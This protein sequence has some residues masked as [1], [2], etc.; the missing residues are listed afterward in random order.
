MTRILILDPGSITGWAIYNRVT[1]ELLDSSCI[2]LSKAPANKLT[3]LEAELRKILAD[4]QPDKIYKE[5]KY[6]FVRGRK[7]VHEVMV[8]ATYHDTIVKVASECKIPI[9]EIDTRRWAKKK[10]AQSTAREITGRKK[11]STHESECICWG[12]LICMTRGL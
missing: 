12:K 10:T 2:R 8:H 6:E 9:V 5:K 7:N 4:Y 1:K 11:I 3:Y